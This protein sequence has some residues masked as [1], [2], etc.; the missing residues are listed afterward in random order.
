MAVNCAAIPAELLESEVFGHERGAF[1]GAHQR[2]LGYAERAR[3]GVLLLDE[4]GAMPLTLQSKILRLL[5]ER[6]FHRVGG[7]TSIPLKARVVCAASENLSDLTRRRLFREDL[8]YRINAVT[9]ELPPFV[10]V[11]KTFLGSCRDIL[12]YSLSKP[13]SRFVA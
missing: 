7:E 4:I 8:L 2:H 6:S 3:S 1:S 11:R 10:T 5:E 13:R 12:R 9:V